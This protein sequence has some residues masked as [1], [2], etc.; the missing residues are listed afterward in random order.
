MA[1]LRN[2]AKHTL[3]IR[4]DRLNNIRGSSMVSISNKL[5]NTHN[6]YV[7]G[8]GF[9]RLR[10]L[11]LIGEC[12]MKMR[13]AL[14]YHASLSHQRECAAIEAVLSFRLNASSAAYRV[15]IDLENIEELFSL[16]SASPSPMEDSIKL[17][18]AAKV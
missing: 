17:A 7:L 8:A 14:E 3:D 16:A 9:S 5:H 2:V 18:I 12:M 13:D 15:Q 11:P 6:V 4:V 10:G 1:H